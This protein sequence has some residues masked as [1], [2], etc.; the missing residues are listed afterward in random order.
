MK[1]RREQSISALERAG[2]SHTP[3]YDRVVQQ[4]RNLLICEPR[5]DRLTNR[6]FTVPPDQLRRGRT[7]PVFQPLEQV[8]HDKDGFF[9]TA[10]TLPHPLNDTST[11]LT[12]ELNAA[13]DLMC[14]LGHD[15]PHW[16]RD[17]VTHIKQLVRALHPLSHSM[18]EARPP[19]ILAA[20]RSPELAFIAAFI[21]AADWPDKQLV[22]DLMKGVQIVGPMPDSGL[23]E[24]KSSVKRTAQASARVSV[25]ELAV[26]STDHPSHGA[27]NGRIRSRLKAQFHLALRHNNTETL[28]HMRRAKVLSDEEVANNMA[29]GPFTFSQLNARFGFGPFPPDL[30]FDDSSGWGAAAG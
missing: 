30:P 9:R 26:G 22:A 1:R 8:S 27:N 17:R 12:K 14:D 23:Y 24:L 18:A 19:H 3:T 25:S 16:R 11:F 21:D 15:L 5:W 6:R 4:L 10:L 29:D 13:I 28:L 20:A 7:S 2:F